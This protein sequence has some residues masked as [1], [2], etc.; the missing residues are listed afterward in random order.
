MAAISS[1]DSLDNLTAK[2]VRRSLE[3]RLGLARGSLHER[4]HEV[5]ALI[6]EVLGEMRAEEAEAGEE[7]EEEV[8]GWGQEG[9]EQEDGGTA[10]SSQAAPAGAS[11]GFK[12]GKWS[13][14]E[15]D[16]CDTALKTLLQA[17][18]GLDPR[19]AE[20]RAFLHPD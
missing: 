9:E 15:I 11:S 8:L 20:F 19:S 1:G 6:D 17:S 5:R 3:S 2:S 18:Y 14:P 4:R 13:K 16:A 12:H 7:A 10:G